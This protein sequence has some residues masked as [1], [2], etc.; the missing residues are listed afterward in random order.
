M[1][2]QVLADMIDSIQISGKSINSVTIIRNGYLVNETYFYP[3][4]KGY[5]HA[6]NSDTKSVLSAL[7]GIAISEGKIKSV[8]DKVLDY[9]PDT[10]ITNVDER[11]KNMTIRDLLTM[12]TGLD[13]QFDGNVSTSEMLQSPDWTHNTH[14]FLY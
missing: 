9:F 3:Y 1:D 12:R 11:K 14:K 7:V 4:Q 6:L 8:D 10:D 2:P 13:W 5:R